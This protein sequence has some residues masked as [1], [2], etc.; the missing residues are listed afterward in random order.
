M[1]QCTQTPPMWGAAP[2]PGAAPRTAPPWAELLGPGLVPGVGSLLPLD[3]AAIGT[4]LGHR[5][6][7][8]LPL[9]VGRLPGLDNET[10]M[11]NFLKSTGRQEPELFIPLPI[12]GWRGLGGRIRPSKSCGLALPGH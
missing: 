3:Q 9:A 11:K 1:H 4:W 7:A 8:T 2:R 6:E 10:E 12:G 5:S